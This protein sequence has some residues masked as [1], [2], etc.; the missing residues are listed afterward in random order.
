MSS[1]QTDPTAIGVRNK[2]LIRRLFDEVIPSGDADQMRGLFTPDWVDHDPLPGQPPGLDGAEYVVRAM[3][4]AHPD[5]HFAIDDL[6]AEDDRVT[7]R[8]TLLGTNT[9][10][11]LGRAPTG[12]PVEY[13]AI[14]IFRIAD[15]RIAE[16]WAGWKR[17]FMP[18]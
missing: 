14:V 3:H 8:F 11:F 15:G 5:V 18:G 17:G 12:L 2:A 16:R 4:G 7:I 1:L 9:R 13:K 10:R 6:L